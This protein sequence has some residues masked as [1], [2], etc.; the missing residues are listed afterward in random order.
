[1]QPSVLPNHLCKSLNV[2]SFIGC[3][4]SKPQLATRLQGL[5]WHSCSAQ[6]PALNAFG[7]HKSP[8]RSRQTKTRNKPSKLPM[9]MGRA[10]RALC[11]R[12]LESF[13]IKRAERCPYHSALT[14]Q[15]KPPTSIPCNVG[16]ATS[17]TDLHCFRSADTAL[18][19]N[20]RNPHGRAAR[21]QG[22]RPSQFASHP[23]PTAMPAACEATAP[24][25]HYGLRQPKPLR[26]LQV[27]SA[28]PWDN[29][30]SGSQSATACVFSSCLQEPGPQQAPQ[31][32]VEPNGIVSCVCEGFWTGDRSFID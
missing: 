28:S 7:L 12:R 21:N 14:L 4:V 30:I 32:H 2:S 17:I 3:K 24:P 19:Q 8:S 9:P 13:V 27:L 25:Q 5:H 22:M 1:M 20:H 18:Q 10:S 11:V 29:N 15:P 26:L 6:V 31:E 23:G 16:T